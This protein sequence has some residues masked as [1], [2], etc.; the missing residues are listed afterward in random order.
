MKVVCNKTKVNE[1]MYYMEEI[2]LLLIFQEKEFVD[3]I[4]G[5]STQL[6]FERMSVDKDKNQQMNFSKKFFEFLFRRLD[7]RNLD[8]LEAM[9]KLEEIIG[10]FKETT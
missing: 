9:S 4:A 10:G 5:P 8:S 7:E 6:L 1:T 3:L 2:P